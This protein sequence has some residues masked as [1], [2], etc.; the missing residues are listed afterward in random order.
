MIQDYEKKYWEDLNKAMIFFMGGCV[1]FL[2]GIAF[3][4]MIN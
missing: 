2:L 3:T 1:G 4:S